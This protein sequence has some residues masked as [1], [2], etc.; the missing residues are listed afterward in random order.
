MIILFKPVPFQ[1]VIYI[2][3]I[4][5]LTFYTQTLYILSKFDINSCSILHQFYFHIDFLNWDPLHLIKNR[6]Y[7]LFNLIYILFSS[8]K[9]TLYAQT[10]YILSKIDSISCSICVNFSIQIVVIVLNKKIKCHFLK[11]L[12]CVYWTN[13]KKYWKGYGRGYGAAESPAL[14]NSMGCKP[15]RCYGN[16]LVGFSRILPGYY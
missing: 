6:H 4:F 2:N 7:F 1:S 9:L 11:K 5:K 13:Q 8:F 12:K 16:T 3:F 14:Q 15:T 10:I